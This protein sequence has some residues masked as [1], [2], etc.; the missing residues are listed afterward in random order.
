MVSSSLWS[1]C[2]KASLSGC[3]LTAVA[4]TIPWR[5]SES[6]SSSLAMP[7]SAKSRLRLV[8][9]PTALLVSRG[10][11]LRDELGGRARGLGNRLG[12]Q[13][14]LHLLDLLREDEIGVLLHALASLLG[15]A[16]DALLV[17]LPLLAEVAADALELLVD[18][19][20]L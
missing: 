11:A 14:L 17:A 15:F 18:L 10:E 16:H 9:R 20:E 2:A 6:R 5:S 4:R 8:K 13:I 3:A 19:G 1:L 12:E 7:G